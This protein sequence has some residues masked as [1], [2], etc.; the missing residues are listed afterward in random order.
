MNTDQSVNTT[1]SN[2]DTPD[3][4]PLT[5]TEYALSDTVLSAVLFLLSFI[6]I[7]SMPFASYPLGTLFVGTAFFTFSLIFLKRSGAPVFCGAATLFLILGVLF[8]VA[9]VFSSNAFVRTACTLP[10]VPCFMLYVYFAK[11]NGTGKAVGNYIVYDSAS[12]FLSYPFTKG[13][14]GLKAIFSPLKDGKFKNVGTHIGYIFFGLA[15]AIIPS[16]FVLI[17]LSYDN[18]FTKL[19]SDV[20]FFD[21]F[22]SVLGY[23]VSAFFAIPLSLYLYSAFTGY[24]KSKSDEQR[25]KTRNSY[26]KNGELKRTLPALTAVSACIPLIFLYVV[27][28]V[29]QF[30]DYTLA[31]RKL[32]PEDTIYSEYARNGFF[33][34][35]RVA[36]LNAFI[37]FITDVLVKKNNEKPPILQKICSVALSV[38]SLVLI[39]TAMAKMMLYID[40]YGMTQKRIFVSLFMIFLALAFIFVIIAQFVVRLK[41]SWVC[42]LLGAAFLLFCSFANIDAHIAYYNVNEYMSADNK[43]FDF[44]STHDYGEAAL[45]ALATLYESDK[46]TD[47]DKVLIRLIASQV[48]ADHENENSLFRFSIPSHKADEA[49]KIIFG[50]QAD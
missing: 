12:A 15:L 38:C 13:K 47:S 43:D 21:N 46:A 19:L 18:K 45:P 37:I 7:R 39:S 35:C 27:F 48:R 10:S 29:A 2:A 17:N 24:E 42:I 22:F 41:M 28:F 6:L 49:L 33:E 34:L 4:D 40:A 20:L 30:E 36:G 50:E 5:G 31:F 25:E 44:V 1:I 14:N 3:K 11:R 16:V 8:S 23:A 9:P 32:L 26:I